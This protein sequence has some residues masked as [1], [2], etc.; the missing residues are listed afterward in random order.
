MVCFFRVQ[1]IVWRCVGI[2]VSPCWPSWESVCLIG[3]VL[4]AKLSA[5]L[6]GTRRACSWISSV[7]VYSINHRNATSTHCHK[8]VCQ[9][10]VHTWQLLITPAGDENLGNIPIPPPAHAVV[11]KYHVLPVSNWNVFSES[12]MH[13]K[14]GRHLTNQW[15][16][17]RS[18][19]LH[20]FY[21]WVVKHL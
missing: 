5:E 1:M 21:G 6:E 17:I 11:K 14:D 3:A 2:M 16:F 10:H 4:T 19:G 8:C 12:I 15:G 20:Q 7:S 9:T 13:L 18:E